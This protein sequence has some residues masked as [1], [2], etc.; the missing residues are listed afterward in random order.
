MHLPFVCCTQVV[1]KRSNIPGMSAEAM[2]MRGRGRGR[3]RGGFRGGYRGSGYRGGYRG[4]YGGP[5][6][7]SPY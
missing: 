2:Y 3:G 7:W 4:G 5:Q 6:R 1:P